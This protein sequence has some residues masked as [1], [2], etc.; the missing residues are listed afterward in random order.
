MAADDDG[1]LNEANEALEEINS[2]QANADKAS[3]W[4]RTLS[5]Y[6]S[7]IFIET[8]TMTFFAGT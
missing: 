3:R 8:F 2:R 1:D 7:L 5:K 4:K 6:L